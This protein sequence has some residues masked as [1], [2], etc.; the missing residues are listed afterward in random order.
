M[1]NGDDVSA[2]RALAISWKAST[3]TLP[4]AARVDAPWIDKNGAPRGS[5]PFC[6]PPQ[7][8]RNNLLPGSR[9]AIDLFRDLG[10]PWH[11]GV[12]GGPGNHLLVKSSASTPCTRWSRIP[13]ASPRPST[14]CSTSP[15]SRRSN[16][17]VS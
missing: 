10:I 7:Y 11:S 2:Q 9:Q 4:D 5:Y 13:P 12:D 17:G 15:T 8:A 6:V 3:P 16:L 14:A 1:S